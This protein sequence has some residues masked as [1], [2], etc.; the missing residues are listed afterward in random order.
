MASTL[1]NLVLGSGVVTIGSD[2]GYYTDGFTYQ[3]Q[4]EHFV[5]NNVES[6]P[7]D[8]VAIMTNKKYS[9]AFTLVEPT[10]ANAKIEHDI[11]AATSGTDPVLLT[12]DAVALVQERVVVGK[13]IV[14]GE[15]GAGT[16]DTVRTL[17]FDRCYAD[18]PGEVKFSDFENTKVPCSFATLY[19]TGNSRLGQYS[20]ATT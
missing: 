7:S 11:T 15:Q 12:I 6:V 19:D 14:P 8:L 2:L 18:S 9:I 17:T 5:V 16:T 4:M 3:A 1:A 20:D 10:L 13:G